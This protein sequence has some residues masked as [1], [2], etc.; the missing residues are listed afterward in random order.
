MRLRLSALLVSA[1]IRDVTDR[2]LTQKE[3]MRAAAATELANRELESFSYSVAHDLKAPLRGIDGF[4][5]ALLSRYSEN[6]DEQGQHYLKRLRQSAK[7][8]SE[9]IE[10]L[11]ILSRITRSDLRHE[12]VDLSSLARRSI[13]GLQAAD[14][15]RTTQFIV[16]PN[17]TAVG[18]PRLLAVLLENL[19][20]NAWKFTR[21]VTPGKI[22]LHSE[23]QDGSTVFC[24]RDN[25]AG[26]DMAY[27]DKLFGVF[28][29]LH[30]EREF[31]GTGIGLATVYRIVQRHDGR[32]W[33]H[34][35]VSE[36]AAFFFTLHEGIE[37]Q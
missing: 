3:M 18:D 34:G 21:D 35:A 15:D 24:V 13:E 28:Q 20:G 4:S 17:L 26:F 11:L 22:E 31:E 32:I 9:L 14:P 2:V 12:V 19:L 33:A 7:R 6:L 25:G 16:A 8:M 5:Q 23:L 30:T 36:G 1:A 10:G 27:A 37:E 29:R